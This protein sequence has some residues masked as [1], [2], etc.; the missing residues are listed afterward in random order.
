MVSLSC[1]STSRGSGYLE[2][3]TGYEWRFVESLSGV[4]TPGISCVNM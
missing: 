1:K 4:H 2:F 3:G